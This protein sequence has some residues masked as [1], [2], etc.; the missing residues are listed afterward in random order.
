VAIAVVLVAERVA[1]AGG[2]SIGFPILWVSVS[3]A[4]TVLVTACWTIA[5]SVLDARQAK[6]LFPLAASAAILG[7]FIGMVAAGPA[8]GLLGAENLVALEA[9]LVL[10]G[11]AIVGRMGDRLRRPG[12]RSPRASLV[13][14]IGDGF[15]YTAASPLMR[16]VA[17]AYVLFA[18]LLFSVSFPFYRAMSEAFAGEAELATALGLVSA[19]VTAASFIVSTTLANRVFRRFG[20]T[21]AALALPIVYLGGFAVWLV[22]FALP[23]AVAVRVAQQV[24][25]RGVSNAAW[26]SFFNVVPSERR[27]QVLAFIDG[28]P[29][30]LGTALSGIL[31]LAAAALAPGQVLWLGLSAAVVC[32]LVVLGVRRRY[33]DSLVRTLREGLAEQIL[34]GGPGIE[35]LTRDPRVLGDL[36]SALG[37]P[38]SGDRRL[39]AELL[40]RLGAHGATDDLVSA[41]ADP[42]PGVRRA[43]LD[44]LAVLRADATRGGF[45]DAL[46][47]SLDDPIAIVR[48]AAVAASAA[49]DAGVLPAVADTVASDPSPAVRAELAVA[50]VRAGEEDRPHRILAALLEAEDPADRIAGLDA[51]RRL[52]GHAPSPRIAASL[53]G[54]AAEVRAAAVA[55]I[56]AVNEGID[57][58]DGLLIG[59]LDDAA[60]VVR[61]A[62]ARALRDRGGAADSVLAVLDHG[63]EHAQAAALLA[64]DGRGPEVAPRLLRWAEGQVRRAI[65]LRRHALA[66]A[67]PVTAGAETDAMGHGEAASAS[68]LQFLLERRGS[69]IEDRLLTALAVLGAPDAS[70]LIRRCLRSND[71][72]TRAQAIEA[73]EALGD[74]RLARAVVE[75]L[76]IEPSD[77]SVPAH[78]ALAGLVDDPDPWVRALALRTLSEHLSGEWRAVMERSAGDPDPIVRAVVASGVH[79]GGTDMPQTGATLGD[80]DRIMFLRRVP[81]FAELGPEDLQRLA[82]TGVERFYPGGEALVREGELGDELVVIV[83]GTVRVV[84][85]EAGVERLLRTYG[86]GDHIGEL[87][88]L[89]ERPRAATVLADEPGVRGLVIGGEGLKAILRERPEAAW[90][91][92]ATLA[93]RIG[94]Q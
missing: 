36:R 46:R 52:G 47:H 62:A 81:L 45:R 3:A 30:Q 72:E 93:E 66:L 2:A 48:V 4:G 80:V 68:F 67:W 88:V 71:A 59:A 35:A 11:A 9:G 8:A 70:G 17:V 26:S 92:L 91:L 58:V 78:E 65:V 74:R 57:D 16:L 12:T 63:S 7:G 64:L 40:A 33:G 41:V 13:S 27:G 77:R 21:A 15:R 50:L 86:S 87:A 20:V 94:A 14:S 1:L 28:V 32:T 56:A 54:P 18:V 76:E 69:G 5:G 44:A 34:E 24:T 6:R 42:D 43:A 90:A 82:M 25:Q 29:G 31:L 84:R 85:H 60:R 53:R 55:A 89:R 83:E 23:T 22:Q 19:V 49:C 61:E 79:D 39:A 51:V 75:L 73:L 10:V 38:R 37:S